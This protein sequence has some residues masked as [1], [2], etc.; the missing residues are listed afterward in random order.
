[1]SVTFPLTSRVAITSGELRT[2][3]STAKISW[4][5]A[6]PH[7]L[8]ACRLQ[9]DALLAHPFE[10]LHDHRFN[11]AY[12][13]IHQ[14]WTTAEEAVRLARRLRPSGTVSPVRCAE[15]LAPLSAA[16]ATNPP[17]QPNCRKGREVFKP[18]NW[19]DRVFEIGIIG[20]GLN[21][22]AELVGGLLLLFLTPDRIHHLRSVI[23]HGVA[24]HALSFARR[25]SE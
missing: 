19:L 21:G 14:T 25:A 16:R 3:L 17:D 9:H 11:Y 18:K 13:A 10:W 4:P 22:A 2:R 23:N 15:R 1:M 12:R 7:Q 20:K 5:D 24:R 6:C 8:P